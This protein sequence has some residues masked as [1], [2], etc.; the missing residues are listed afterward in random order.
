MDAATSSAPVAAPFNP[1]AA[2]IHTCKNCQLKFDA[3]PTRQEGDA[4]RGLC[5]DCVDLDKAGK[6][7]VVGRFPDAAFQGG[8]IE[9][10]KEGASLKL[11]LV[12]DEGTPRRSRICPSMLAAP[13]I[14]EEM[15]EET[16]ELTCCECGQEGKRLVE[17]VCLDCSTDPEEVMQERLGEALELLAEESGDVINFH[18]FENSGLLTNNKGLVVTIDGKKFHLTI[19]QA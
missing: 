18:S 16:A 9:L 8:E 3:A 7:I 19:V 13:G 1:P 6:P 11:V 4:E 12:N 14:A 10:R 17:G 5:W 15:W 2:Q